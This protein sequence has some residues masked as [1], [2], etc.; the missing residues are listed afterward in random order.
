MKKLFLASG[1]ASALVYLFAVVLGGLLR[2]DYSHVS[3]AISELTGSGAPNRELL[4]VLFNIYGLLSI[5]FA[6]A[7]LNHVKAYASRAADASMILFLVISVFTFLWVFFPMDERGAEATFKGAVHIAIAAVV[8]PSTI[9]CMLL[10]GLGFK[11]RK[12]MKGYAV[13]SLISSALVLVSGM[14]AAISPGNTLLLPYMGLF[15]RVTIGLYLLWML[16]TSIR[17][18]SQ[19]KRQRAFRNG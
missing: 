12:D 2:R 13:Y 8:S 7:A 6:I 17:F 16:V 18:L 1:A 19:E 4:N 14:M 9:I 3:H 11:R 5:V 15:E 10:A